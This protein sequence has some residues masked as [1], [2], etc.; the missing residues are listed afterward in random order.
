VAAASEYGGEFRQDIES[1]VTV[2][3]VEA[4]IVPDRH[5]LP[6]VQ[7]IRYQAFTDPSGG[8][9]DS[10]TLAVGHKE[11][12]SAV[13]DLVVERKPPFNPESAVEEFAATLKQYRVTKVTGDKYAGEFPRELFRKHGI[14]YE[15]SER[16]KSDLYQELLPL[17][18]SGRVALLDDRRLATRLTQLERRTARSGRDSIDHGP[19]GRDDLA[20]SVAGVLVVASK[21]VVGGGSLA[22]TPSS[23]PS[24]VP[25]DWGYRLPRPGRLF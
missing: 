3:A 12:E 25:V 2:E 21:S 18:N 24:R 1:Y 6:P 15:P 14:V 7:G 16:T 20:N 9:Q 5:Q 17:L 11:K 10:F 13:F 22:W 8:S 23:M 4:C 19:G